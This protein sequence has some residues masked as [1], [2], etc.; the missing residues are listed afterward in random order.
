MIIAEIAVSRNTPTGV[1][2]TLLN[3][4]KNTRRKKHPHRCGEDGCACIEALT[5]LET[6]PQVWGRPLNRYYSDN[7]C[8]T[9]PQVWGRRVRVLRPKNITGNTPTG[10]GKTL[11][12]TEPRDPRW[13]H[14]H[15][16]GEDR[17]KI[18][19]LALSEETPP[20]VWGRRNVAGITGR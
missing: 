11:L 18:A 15:R 13:K 16:C 12:L 14:P 9:P 17:Y 6:P 8:E 7:S 10:V 3:R 5:P 20:Q 1:G 2:K 4:K 19:C